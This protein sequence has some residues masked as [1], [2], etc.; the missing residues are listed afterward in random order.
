MAEFELRNY[1]ACID[2]LEQALADPTK[3]LPGA[4]RN[5][6]EAL[7]ARAREFVARVQL[8]VRPL[9]RETTLLVDG[10]PVQRRS[11]GSLLLPVGE[12]VLELSAQGYELEKRK[13]SLVGGHDEQLTILLRERTEDLSTAPT[14]PAEQKRTPIYKSPWLWVGV[15]V[16]VVGGAAALG[17]GLA[18]R[19]EPGE[20]T[21]TGSP[22]VGGGLI[23][24]LRFGP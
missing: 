13:L 20:H 12:H 16:V 14:Q 22:E 4:L 24:T 21:V 8:S 11:D 19:K 10:A 3:P 17:A 23:Q 7:L 2:D 18:L 1:L 5:D 15:A 6:T 9:L